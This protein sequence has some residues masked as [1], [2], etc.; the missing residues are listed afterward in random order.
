[1]RNFS[2]RPWTRF[3]LFLFLACPQNCKSCQVTEISATAATCS[4]C[5]DNYNPINAVD[6]STTVDGMC[7]S[8]YHC[9]IFYS[10]L[11][12]LIAAIIIFIISNE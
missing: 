11:L 7:Y 5:N 10:V 6:G 4:K 12:D 8:M 3:G 2:P 1:M 9:S